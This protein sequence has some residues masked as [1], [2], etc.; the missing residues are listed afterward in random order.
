MLEIQP[1]NQD[2]LTSELVEEKAERRK[3]SEMVFDLIQENRKLW[4]E[5]AELREKCARLE[6]R[7]RRS[8]APLFDENRNIPCSNQLHERP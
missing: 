1:C 7:Q 4:K 3:L 5:N 2:N 8:E 6:E